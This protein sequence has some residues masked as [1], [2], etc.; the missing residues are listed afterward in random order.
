MR[1][2]LIAVAALA[3][4]PSVAA[5]QYYAD[6]QAGLPFSEAVRVGD[7]LIL[8]GQIGFKPGQAAPPFETEAKQAMDNVAA[9][10][11]RHGASMADVVKCTVFLKD[12]SKFATFNQIYASYF[13]AGHYPARSA[14]APAALALP[15]ATVEVECWAALPTRKRE[16]DRTRG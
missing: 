6:P 12:M 16:Q 2:T 13:K 3:A 4:T 7:L 1:W 10:L 14:V 9:V 5:P 15:D 8:S 11:G